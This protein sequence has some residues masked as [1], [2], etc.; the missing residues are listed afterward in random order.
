MNNLPRLVFD[1]LKSYVEV[2][3]VFILFYLE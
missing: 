3:S 2:L 1:D